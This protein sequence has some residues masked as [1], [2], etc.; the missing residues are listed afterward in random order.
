MSSESLELER[1]KH[2]VLNKILGKKQTQQARIHNFERKTHIC[3]REKLPCD[4]MKV[5]GCHNFIH[6]I[7]NNKYTIVLTWPTY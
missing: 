3:F 7:L 5:H 1:S 4:I 2:D 6:V